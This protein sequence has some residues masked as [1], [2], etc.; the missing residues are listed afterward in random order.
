MLKSTPKALRRTTPTNGAADAKPTEYKP[1]MIAQEL[2]ERRTLR[3]HFSDDS[4]MAD[5]LAR[6]LK[7]EC[8]QIPENRIIAEAV[9]TCRARFG[10][11]DAETVEAFLIE[12]KRKGSGGDAERFHSADADADVR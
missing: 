5:H 10:K 12:P 8:F 6:Y 1:Q 3:S 4:N 11:D 7:P 9:W 2:G